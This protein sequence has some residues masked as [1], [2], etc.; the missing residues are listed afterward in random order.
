MRT[1]TTLN[2]INKDEQQIQAYFILNNKI[3]I[4]QQINTLE[5]DANKDL[6]FKSVPV[7]LSILITLLTLVIILFYCILNFL[8]TTHNTLV[9]FRWAFSHFL[10]TQI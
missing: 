2:Y 7:L 6:Y 5:P 4:F 3:K 1:F 8:E 9:T 10:V